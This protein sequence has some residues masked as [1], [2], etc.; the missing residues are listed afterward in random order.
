[1]LLI[2]VLRNHEKDSQ[3]KEIGLLFYSKNGLIQY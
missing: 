3:R 1:M 2:V